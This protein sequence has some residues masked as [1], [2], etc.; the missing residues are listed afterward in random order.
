MMGDALAA[1]LILLLGVLGLK[2]HD[3]V[4]DLAVLGTGVKDAGSA[5]TEGFGSAGTP[6]RARP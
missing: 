3:A 6:S 4:D 1:L 2:V 5:V